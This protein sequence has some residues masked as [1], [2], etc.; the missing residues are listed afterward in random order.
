MMALMSKINQD[1]PDQS[2]RFLDIANANRAEK[3]VLKGAVKKIAAH[4]RKAPKPK[5]AQKAR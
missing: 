3:E 5:S 2:R 4:P 1:D